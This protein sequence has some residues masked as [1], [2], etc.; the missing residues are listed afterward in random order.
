MLFFYAIIFSPFGRMKR[1]ALGTIDRFMEA[2][3]PAV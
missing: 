2:S 3:I 1:N